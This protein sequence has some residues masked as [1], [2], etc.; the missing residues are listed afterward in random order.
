MEENEL[1]TQ[2]TTPENEIED[3]F[4]LL[5]KFNKED[6]SLDR[7]TAIK[8]AQKGMKYE[9]IEN[10]FSRIKELAKRN[11]NTL[12]QYVSTLEQNENSNYENYL[13]N[14]CQGD[15]VLCERILHLENEAKQSDA[16]AEIK[17]NFPEIDS[18]DKL[19]E[20]VI[21][22]SNVRGSNL[23][24]EYLRYL[25]RLQK[26]KEAQFLAQRDGESI[27]VGE[28]RNEKQPETDT[29]R[30]EFIKGIWARN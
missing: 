22:N 23:L 17:D 6:V 12:S 1:L 8:Y 2:D 13:L 27:T 24:D 15:K 21:E 9:L 26:C 3:D 18:I 28:M 4:N 30:S 29:A 11:G 7:D 14:K 19:P 20:E 10:D 5:V 16:I 25:L